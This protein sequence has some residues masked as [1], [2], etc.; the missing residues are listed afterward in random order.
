MALS[1]DNSSFYYAGGHGHGQ[2]QGPYFQPL[3]CAVIPGSS[4]HGHDAYGGHAQLVDEQSAAAM[5][6]SWFSARGGGGYDVNGSG[7]ILPAQGHPHP[8]TLSMSSG[9]GSQSSCVTMQVGAHPDPHADAVA[10]YIAM[11]GNG[12]KKRGGA[13]ALQKQ[14]TVHRKSIDTFG[15][16]TSQYRGVTRYARPHP[17]TVRT[18]SP[19]HPGGR[20]PPPHESLTSRVVSTVQKQA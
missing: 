12:S 10:E 13:G 14:P 2:D 7:A 15:Q 8:L 11:D 3:H 6:A 19:S 4:A 20:R 18:P 17:P 9:S 1:L 16:R 5:A